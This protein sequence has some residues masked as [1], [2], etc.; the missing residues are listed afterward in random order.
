MKNKIV[1]GVDEVGR[2][3]LAGPVVAGAVVWKGL[4]I[5]GLNDSK[6]LNLKQREEVFQQCLGRSLIYATGSADVNEIEERNILYATRLAMERAVNLVIDK[7]RVVPDI[8]LIDGKPFTKGYLQNIGT[9]QGWIVK[10][11]T[12][13]PAIMAASIFA[14]VLR[15]RYMKSLLNQ[16]PE[17]E[18]YGWRTNVG[19]GT[20]QHIEAIKK[21]GITP[22]HRKTFQ[23]IKRWLKEG[24]ID[25]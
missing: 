19:Y 2:G 9:G 11:D 6:Q 8:T 25:G 14:K 13:V 3:S 1:I 24:V 21:Y 15:D 17:Y 7:V 20:K 23:P 4:D 12:I 22:F 18:V 10:G 5:E 16:F